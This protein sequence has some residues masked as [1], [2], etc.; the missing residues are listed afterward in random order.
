MPR[1]LRPVA[2]GLVYHLVGRGNNR[3]PVFL[4]KGDFQAFL[5]ALGDLKQRKP[6]QWYGCC[7]MGIR[8]HW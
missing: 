8:V 4:G 3:Q 2:E 5:K 6:F 7:L 1:P